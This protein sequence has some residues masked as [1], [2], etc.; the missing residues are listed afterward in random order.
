MP[1]K[2]DIFSHPTENIFDSCWTENRNGA[3]DEQN[4][5]LKQK[6]SF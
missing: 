1:D 3:V 2:K 4:S 6:F 5:S